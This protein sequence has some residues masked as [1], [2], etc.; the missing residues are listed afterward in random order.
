MGG[1]GWRRPGRATL[2]RGVEKYKLGMGMSI[3]CRKKAKGYGEGRRNSKAAQ[4]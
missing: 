1:G 4:I 2:G 3:K